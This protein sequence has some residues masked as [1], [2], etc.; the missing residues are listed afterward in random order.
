[1]CDSQ[2]LP[3]GWRKFEHPNGDIYYHNSQLRATTMLNI[4][5][6]TM[7][8]RVVDARDNHLEA[9]DDDVAMRRLPPDLELV[10]VESSDTTPI[11]FVK[12]YSRARG[13]GYTWRED[14]GAY[15]VY[16]IWGHV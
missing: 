12:M 3:R 13:E 11:I 9:L 16:Y 7:Y 4:R 2:P 8:Q 6:P 15:F 5:D 10:L 14:D 1:M